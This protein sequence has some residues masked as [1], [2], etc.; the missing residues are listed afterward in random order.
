MFSGGGGYPPATALDLLEENFHALRHFLTRL[1]VIL[2]LLND[3]HCDF[4]ISSITAC[5]ACL[6][7]SS[8]SDSPS[9]LAEVLLLKFQNVIFNILI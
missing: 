3:S 1:R 7:V 4:T 9:G 6:S 2:F 5:V 8:Y